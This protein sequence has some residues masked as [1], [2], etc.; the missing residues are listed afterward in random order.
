[1]VNSAEDE[2]R[3]HG[4]EGA[5]SVEKEVGQSEGA[6][7]VENILLGGVASGVSRL[8]CFRDQLELRSLSRTGLLGKRWPRNSWD[9]KVPPYEY[10]VRKWAWL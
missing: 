1:M 5:H 7:A 9:R 10:R 4:H 3:V 2:E 6:E 8:C